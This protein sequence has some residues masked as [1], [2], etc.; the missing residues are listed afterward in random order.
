ML[1]RGTS[2]VT[3]RRPDGKSKRDE[4]MKSIFLDLL[5]LRNTPCDHQQK[6]FCQDKHGQHSQLTN[7]VAFPSTKSHVTVRKPLVHKC[8]RQKQNLQWS[9]HKLVKGAIKWESSK[10]TAGNQDHV[11]WNQK[12]YNPADHPRICTEFPL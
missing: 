6:D 3:R 8:N 7:K 5:N 2:S 9:G 11:W 12:D 4:E 1:K 10:K